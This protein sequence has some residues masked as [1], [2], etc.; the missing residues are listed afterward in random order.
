MANNESNDI[1]RFARH[2]LRTM[3]GA[4]MMGAGLGAGI[5]AAKNHRNKTPLQKFMDR[6]NDKMP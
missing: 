5:M 3:G 1:G 6:I 4:M 2:P